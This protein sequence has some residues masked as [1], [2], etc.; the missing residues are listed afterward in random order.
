VL[1]Q[2]CALVEIIPVLI[3]DSRHVSNSTRAGGIASTLAAGSCRRSTRYFLAAGS[4]GDWAAGS[5]GA[6]T[7]RG[8]FLSSL[9]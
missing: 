3:I 5:V 7:G 9:S 8:R 1:R 4:S 2:V 6:V